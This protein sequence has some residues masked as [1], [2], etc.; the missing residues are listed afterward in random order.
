ASKEFSVVEHFDAITQLIISWRKLELTTWPKLFEREDE[1]ARRAALGWWFFLYES[2]VA[3][4]LALLQDGQNL[5][6]HARQLVDSLTSFMV[7]SSVGQFKYRLGLVKAFEQHV[8]LLA[9]NI[10]PKMEIVLRAIKNF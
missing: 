1:K 2:I 8:E 7:T 5:S 9:N 6:D 4:P 3:N 10:N